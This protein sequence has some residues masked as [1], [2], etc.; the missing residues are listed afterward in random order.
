MSKRIV[1]L[2]F[3]VLFFIGL[4]AQ[5]RYVVVDSGFV[6][7]NPPFKSCHASTIVELEDGTVLCAWFGGD[8]EGHNNVSIW[9]SGFKGSSWTYPAL[10]ADGVINDSTRFACWNPVLY[11]DK[12]TAYLFYKVGKSPSTWWGEYKKSTDNGKTWSKSIKLPDGIL[13]P[14]KNK[15]IKAG[16]VILNPSSTETTGNTKWK[17]FI[18]ISDKKFEKWKKIPIDTVS[19]FKVIQPTLLRYSKNKL[20]ALMRSDSNEILQS[21]S[22]DNGKSWSK[23]TST[24]IQNPNSGIDAVNLKDGNKLLVYNPTQK[25][26]DWWEGRNKLSVLETTDGRIWF[27]ILVLEEHIKGE[28]SYPAIIQ[29]K[30]GNIFITYTYDRKN[31][32]YVLI[33][34]LE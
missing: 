7:K 30:N 31:I 18:E 6:F 8:Q 11:N 20:Q 10:V 23:I 22:S 14:V 34:A 1:L 25:G 27:D 28:F 15:P 26:R 17:S 13:G 32:K 16:N 4:K 33:K 5:N 21:W 3:F 29:L 24:H 19:D 12:N 9:T 2:S